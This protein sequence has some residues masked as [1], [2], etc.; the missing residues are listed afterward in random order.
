MNIPP[1]T[2]RWFAFSLPCLFLCACQPNAP[3]ERGEIEAAMK[4]YDSFILQTNPDSI[5]MMYTPQGKL[6]IAATGRDS[7]RAFL[8][9]FSGIRVLTQSSVTD[10]IRLDKDTA[11]Q[12]GRYKQSDLIKA[13]DTARISGKYSARWIWS[14]EEGWRLAEMVTEPDKDH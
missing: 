12:A 13:G 14:D 11:W 7:I 1:R 4:K 5:A 3:H 10:S 9:R 2:L 8:Q 6:G